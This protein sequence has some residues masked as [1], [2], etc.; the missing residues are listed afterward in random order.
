MS[1]VLPVGAILRERYVIV[2]LVGQGGMGA[3][4]QA[5]DLRLRG[6]VCAVKEVL[7]EL[8]GL[9]GMEEQAHDQFY[10]EAS[11]LARLDHPNLPKVSDFFDQDGREYLVMDF[12]PGQD[13]RQLVEDA[14]RKD[15]LLDEPIVLGWADQLCDALTYLHTQEPPVLHRDIK[16]SNVKLTPRGLVKLVDFG[17]VKLLQP[18]ESRTVTVVQGR[19][20]VA[21]TP[22]E[23]Y[24]GDTGH[25]DVRS[26]IYSLG[27]T[28]YH[29]VTGQPP[30]DA[31]Q[32]FL[33]PGS[34]TP[35]RDLNAHLTTQTEQAI[36]AAMAQHP[37]DRPASIEELRQMLLVRH[38]PVTPGILPAS[39]AG[40]NKNVWLTFLD[41]HRFL[42]G[43]FAVLM[44]LAILV[45]LLAPPL[46]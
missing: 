40:N 11:I 6:R 24:G 33:R 5:S 30:A 41:S 35:P 28:L 10:R 37:D 39:V 29:L 31:K 34:L 20:T 27:A 45:T 21:Y 17:L 22:L 36:L 8:I 32:R 18:D 13:L 14:R 26:D 23:Q 4:Y 12:V 15:S 38:D 44:V 3:V 46:P 7:P 9:P 43:A 25:T 19:G 1:Q 2:G 42:V 16:P